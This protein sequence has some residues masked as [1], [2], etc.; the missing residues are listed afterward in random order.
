[1]EDKIGSIEVGKFAA[2]SLSV[3]ILRSANHLACWR[4][5]VLDAIVAGRNTSGIT[6]A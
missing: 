5:K 4:S 1:M 6:R 3:R 2:F